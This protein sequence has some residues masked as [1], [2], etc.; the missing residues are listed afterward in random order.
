MGYEPIELEDPESGEVIE[1]VIAYPG[2]EA[3]SVFWKLIAHVI[4]QLSYI[5]WAVRK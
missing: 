4:R 2:M 1:T 3:T 5:A